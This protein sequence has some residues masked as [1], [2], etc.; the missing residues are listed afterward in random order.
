[1]KAEN[2]IIEKIYDAK[3]GKNQDFKTLQLRTTE[4]VTN[5]LN[6]LLNSEGYDK[7]KVA[8]QSVHKDVVAKL[9]LQEGDNL[10][11][12]LGK[13]L[14]IVHIE[15]LAPGVG[16][17]P[18]VNPTSGSAITSNGAQIYF[19]RELAEATKADVFVSRDSVEVSAASSI[20]SSVE[21]QM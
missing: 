3:E 8:F 15:Q 12:K 16:F 21:D 18:M 2:V 7:S 19:K 1:M 13:A 20:F 17:Q 5:F 4:K 6:T 10:G 9:G 11:N 14:R